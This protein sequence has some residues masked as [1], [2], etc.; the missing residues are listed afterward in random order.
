MKIILGA[1]AAVLA[2]AWWFENRAKRKYKEQAT[3]A[4]TLAADRLEQV[5]QL[6]SDLDDKE[7][8]SS[9]LGKQVDRL[10]NSTALVEGRLIKAKNLAWKLMEK[11]NEGQWRND[12]N[13]FMKKGEWKG[14]DEDLKAFKDI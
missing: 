7:K 11:M 9:S 8:V 10:K 5:N 3:S 4:K 2:L 13:L 12:K 14:K 6:M 1:I